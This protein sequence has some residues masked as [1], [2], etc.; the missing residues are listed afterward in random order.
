MSNTFEIIRSVTYKFRLGLATVLQETKFTTNKTHLLIL[1]VK[2]ISQ[3][4]FQRQM[5]TY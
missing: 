2:R 3:V 5:Q 4:T 1:K